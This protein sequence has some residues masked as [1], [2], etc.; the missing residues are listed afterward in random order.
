M[1]IVNSYGLR[2]LPVAMFLN[3]INKIDEYKIE[4]GCGTPARI[5]IKKFDSVSMM[6]CKDD[7]RI[8]M[9]KLRFKEELVT[10]IPYFNKDLAMEAYEAYGDML[11]HSP[12]H[13]G[14]YLSITFPVGGF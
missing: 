2:P 6:A 7:K 12:D 4:N 3:D 11:V 5:E 1:I 9:V 13:I 10:N 14:R 8:I